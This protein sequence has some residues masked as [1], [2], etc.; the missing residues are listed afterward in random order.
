[1]TGGSISVLSP[2]VS[3]SV[4][5]CGLKNTQSG[6]TVILSRAERADQLEWAIR[7]R[8]FVH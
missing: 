6:S 4:M 1:M 3:G 5:A 8:Q 7:Q 2:P